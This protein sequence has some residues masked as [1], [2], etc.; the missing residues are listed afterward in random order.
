MAKRCEY[1][2]ITYRKDTI[3]VEQTKTQDLNVDDFFEDT[4][5]KRDLLRAYG[6]TYIFGQN[7]KNIPLNECSPKTIGDA[8]KERYA[9]AQENLEKLTEKDIMRLEA[10][11]SVILG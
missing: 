5:P 11:A 3:L 10:G 2:P 9:R 8:F 4:V 7:E 1:F 6:Y